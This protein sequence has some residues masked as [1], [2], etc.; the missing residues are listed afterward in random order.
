MII[1]SNSYSQVLFSE[2][3]DGIP[4]VTTGGAGTFSFPAGWT[5][6][7]VDNRVAAASVSYV[8]D[9]WERREDFSFN[10]ADSCAFST[11]WYSPA[12]SADDWMWTPLISNITSNT[13]LKWKAV[14]YDTEYQDGY[15]VR[16]MI[17]PNTPSGSAGVLGNMVDS[18]IVLFS[19]P[20]ES[21]T[22]TDRSV[23]LSAYAGKSVRIAFRNNS[24]DKFLLL[25]D[26][27]IVESILNHDA[28]ISNINK[29][30]YTNIHL[31]QAT[32]I[33]A[34]ATIKNEGLDTI[35]NVYL[36]IDAYASNG[37]LY[38]SFHSDT[39]ALLLPSA[40]NIFTIN[41]L[42]LNLIDNYTFK[43]HPV[44]AETDQVSYNDTLTNSII[45]SDTVYAKDNG[46]QASTLG[47][48][49]GNGGYIGNKFTINNETNLIS[50]TGI[51]TAGGNYKQAYVIWNMVGGIPDSIIATTDTVIHSDIN[52]TIYT[53]GLKGGS[54]HL[55]PGDYTVT[56]VEIDSTITLGMAIDN[57]TNGT[58][59]VNWP[60]IPGGAWKNLE[61]FGPTFAKTPMIRLNVKS[62]SAITAVETITA[63][64][65]D[66]CANGE[67]QLAI[68]GENAPFTYAWNN[69][70]TTNPATNLLSG[71]YTVEVTDNIGC[72]ST[73]N[74]TVAHCTPILSED[75]ITDAS[76]STCADGQILLNIT[77]DNAPF[78][79]DW[80]NTQT[81]N[82]AINLL[83]N[84]YAVT[85]TDSLGCKATFNYTVSFANSINSIINGISIYP[86]P[87][88]GIINFNFT[89]KEI[90]NLKITN[91]TG[92]TIYEKSEIKQIE[93]FDLS[94]FSTG[95]YIITIQSNN[96]IFTTKLIKK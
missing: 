65:C 32:N 51:F 70:Q 37:S 18:S 77:G 23:S 76:C 2:D 30:E 52:Q 7:N 56:A 55:T 45:I 11:S 95:I 42:Q 82:P 69:G 68:T 35:S 26:D 13:I 41:N 22:W 16:I 54:L 90:K 20:N 38:K 8:N 78:T 93:A 84:Q 10:V 14:T 1:I 88:T 33:N 19:T 24:T 36:Q 50:V 61:T 89:N 4:G 43:Y 48:G 44:I 92:K 74:Y 5:L 12:G 91:L 46:V 39:L 27:I 57:F 83:P 73:F 21:S 63:A 79:F 87:T 96:E 49:A 31:S 40:S 59:W 17:A 9:A 75:S 80:N 85:I 64:T 47:I 66:T 6:V 53:I 62:C 67:I 28:S 34:A 71:Q 86:N 3:F 72:E 25:I 58:S 81:T 94:E 15:E 29:F 60:T